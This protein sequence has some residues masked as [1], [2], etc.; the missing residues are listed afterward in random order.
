VRSPSA[1]LALLALLLAPLAG[2]ASHARFKP[3]VIEI[4]T[5][6]P[7]S[8]KI[9]I[10]G[11]YPCKVWDCSDQDPSERPCSPDN[12][13]GDCIDRYGEPERWPQACDLLEEGQIRTLL[14]QAT[15]ITMT[16]KDVRVN[17]VDPFPGS[18]GVAHGASCR[19][20]V[21]LPAV[22]DDYYKPYW[23]IDIE[24]TAA[25]GPNAVRGNY[26]RDL[27]NAKDSATTDHG[28]IV[29][30]TDLGPTSCFAETAPSPGGSPGPTSSPSHTNYY[31]SRRG[32][33]CYR[34]PLSFTIDGP[35]LN[36]TWPAGGVTFRHDGQVSAF[37]D[38]ISGDQY[39]SNVAT[40]A[41]VRCINALIG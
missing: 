40:T 20:Q 28:V 9:T 13:Y 7:V 25:G 23:Y 10:P 3:A 15:A 26:E 33:E 11:P 41:L 21:T 22:S 6:A 27:G 30:R 24:V 16:R 17:G 1:G 29:Q 36:A 37:A 4:G 8:R 18:S 31:G 32:W 12:L 35:G 14:P 5:P 38:E 34:G 19:I 2:C 39:V